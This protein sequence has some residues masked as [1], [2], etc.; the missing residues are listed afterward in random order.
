M[1]RYVFCQSNVKEPLRSRDLMWSL[2]HPDQLQGEGSSMMMMMMMMI[3]MMMMMMMMEMMMTMMLM[4]NM[5][6][7]MMI[8]IMMWLLIMM[9]MSVDNVYDDVDANNHHS[10]Q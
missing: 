9:I 8:I 1:T 4:M 10:S 3:V 5:M 2:C 6:M 7:E